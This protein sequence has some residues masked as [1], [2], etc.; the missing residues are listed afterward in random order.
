MCYRLYLL[1]NKRCGGTSY[2]LFITNM[3]G[4]AEFVLSAMWL[5]NVSYVHLNK[6]LKSLSEGKKNGALEIKVYYL[7]FCFTVYIFFYI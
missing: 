6:C 4:V 3:E 1:L 7:C 2:K 5:C